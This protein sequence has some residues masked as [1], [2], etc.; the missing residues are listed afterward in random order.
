[1]EKSAWL[2]PRHSGVAIEY[3]NAIVCGSRKSSR[4]CASATT[5]AAL[6]SGVKYILYGSSTGM[7]LPGLP[8]SGSIGVTLPSVRPSAL[9][10]T[11]SV[12]KSQRGDG[13]VG[14][15]ADFVLF[16]ALQRCRVDPQTVVGGWIG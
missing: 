9:L 1:M 15:E 14:F 13:V 2:M 6:P 4:L 3:F 8:V 10:L 5:M 16:D 11:H 7:F 12:F